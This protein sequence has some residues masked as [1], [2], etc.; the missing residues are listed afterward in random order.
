MPVTLAASTVARVS[1]RSTVLDSYADD[2][3]AAVRNAALLTDLDHTLRL[4]HESQRKARLA[5]AR[6]AA[7]DDLDALRADI[8]EVQ[9]RRDRAHAEF[10]A[11]IRDREEAAKCK[12][13][14]TAQRELERYEQIER[15]AVRVGVS[16]EVGAAVGAVE[17]S[18]ATA[19]QRA[20]A[21]TRETV[22]AQV[23]SQT[24]WLS[25]QLPGLLQAQAK[26][27][28]GAADGMGRHGENAAAAASAASS[29]ARRSSGGSA[30]ASP[31]RHSVT[32]RTTAGRSTIGEADESKRASSEASAVAAMAGGPSLDAPHAALMAVAASAMQAAQRAAAAQASGDTAGVAA[33]K[34]KLLEVASAALAAANLPAGSS[35]EGT[36]AA[37]Q[38]AAAALTAAGWPTAA[39]G[40][41]PYPYAAWPPPP[42]ACGYAMAPP[43][44]PW[45]THLPAGG[46]WAGM[47]PAAPPP[48]SAVPPDSLGAAQPAGGLQP[49][50]AP[51]QPAM[52]PPMH[53][54]QSCPLPS[55]Q[56]L[57]LDGT[58]AH[59]LPLAPAATEAQT[60]AVADQLASCWLSA[61][62]APSASGAPPPSMPPPYMPPPP[63]AHEAL[64]PSAV[65][66]SAAAQTL[67]RATSVPGPGQAVLSPALSAS[68]SHAR[69]ASCVDGSNVGYNLGSNLGHGSK[70]IGSNLGY[71][72]DLDDSFCSV[73]G[74]LASSLPH[75]PNEPNAAA[76]TE[77]PPQPK[78]TVPA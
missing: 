25:E 15:E 23:T 26:L 59:P 77:L 1:L 13:E 22:A 8:S 52:Q 65:Q 37:T 70:N 72:Q 36:A 41:P 5:Q 20:V 18:I 62:F 69:R 56:G 17:A 43:P 38:G 14:L 11:E 44:P 55:T 53:G 57:P 24:R 66:A 42:Y 68:S 33:A 51:A 31:L 7:T 39:S 48:P 78:Q 12:Q 30:P 21:Q 60:G 73:S 76:S 54:M 28:L 50:H 4:F 6:Q 64:D 16:A 47:G 61:P 19:V 32:S 2:Q 10:E 74:S 67:T 75:E 29:P 49:Q 27:A 71:S 58:A 46:G 63:A 45:A 3:R 35:S 40:P 34:A 9:T